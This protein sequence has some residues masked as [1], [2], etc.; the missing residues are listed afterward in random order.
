MFSRFS[1][2]LPVLAATFLLAGT[3]AVGQSGLQTG[4]SLIT[5]FRITPLAA[6]GAAH[7]ELNPGHAQAPQLRANHAAAVAASPD[8][9]LLAIQTSGW[10]R[11]YDAAGKIIAYLSTEYIFVFDISGKAPVQIQALPIANTFQGLAWSAKTGRLYASGGPDDVVVE[12]APT[13]KGLIRARSFP[14]GHGSAIGNPFDVV[15]GTR[16]ILRP[17]VA[18]LAV[19]PDGTRLLAANLMNDSVSLIDLDIGAVIAEQDLRPGAI[20][21]AQRGRPGGTY[22]R[23]IVWISTNKAYVASERDREIIALEI[24][25]K[26]VRV[27]PRVAVKGQPVALATNRVGTRLYAALDNSDAVAI[28]DTKTDGQI[29]QFNVV[30]PKSIFAN[31]NRLGGANSNALALTPDERTL[32][33][34]NGGQ[35]SLAVVRL[36]DA[37]RGAGASKSARPSAVIGLV[38]TGWYP[39]GVATARDGGNWYVINGKS[40]AAPNTGWCQ[41]LNAATGRCVTD[42]PEADTRGANNGYGFLRSRGQHHLQLQHAGL[43]SFPAP[44]EAELTQL[45]RQ[46]AQN[47]RLDRPDMTPE[48]KKLFDFLRKRIRHVIFV[49]RENRTYD[50]VLGDLDH[51]NG[52]RRFTIYHDAITPNQHALARGFV[53]LDNFLTSGEG[54]WTGWQWSAAARSNDYTERNEFASLAGRGHEFAARGANRGINVGYGSSAE[55]QRHFPEAPSDPDVLV[56]PRD[57][58]ELDGPGGTPG[59]GYI[60]DAVLR[61]GLTVRN[62]GFHGH[63]VPLRAD[64]PTP[65]VRDAHAQGIVVFFPTNPA[66]MPHTDVFYRQFDEGLPDYWRYREWKREFDGF[67]ARGELPNLTLIHFSNDHLSQFKVMLDGVDTPIEQIADNDYAF[68]QIVEAV[69]KSPFAD[70]TIVIS[71]EDGAWDGPDHVSPHRSPVYFAGAYIKQG[72]LVSQRYTTVNVLKTILTVLGAGP[73]GLNDALAAP[74]SEVFDPKASKWTYRAIVPEPL[75][76]TTLPLPPPVAKAP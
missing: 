37:A 57:V 33:V 8:G 18:G 41:L 25:A 63:S 1:P 7:Q 27:G 9:R 62:Y 65:L 40:M 42:A 22:P 14:L 38:P 17:V 44:T 32:L 3:A 13:A 68:G 75:R 46:V 76:Q 72:A 36:G 23:S 19:S 58:A 35:N 61:A 70:S 59:A 73:M 24:G 6:R 20:D 69:S 54:S 26:T 48:D 43:L 56:G 64:K 50:Q 4:E 45:T 67:A 16:K 39:T 12:F 74:M 60:W 53:T 66:L 30:A 10:N 21:P 29:E 52:D 2:L 31:P 28:F 71:V 15:A 55:R 51:G 34:S 11:Q 47:N 49:L 5:G